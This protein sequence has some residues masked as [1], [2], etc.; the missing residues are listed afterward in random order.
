MKQKISGSIIG[1]VFI[2]TLNSN[3]IFAQT[4]S[5]KAGNDQIINLEKTQTL[6]LNGSVSSDKIKSCP[7]CCTSFLLFKK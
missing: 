6:Q 7:K 2:L 1:I 3:L 5:V 4:Y